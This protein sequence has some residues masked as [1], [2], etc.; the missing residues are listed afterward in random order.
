MAVSVRTR[1]LPKLAISL[2]LALPACHGGGVA[3]SASGPRP[4]TTPSSPSPTALRFTVAPFALPAPLQR[5]VAV[6]AGGTIELAGGL[7]ASDASTSTVDAID[8]EAR[9]VA[10]LG[11]IP[12]PFHDG[13]GAVIGGRVFV[14][15][16]GSASSSD[17]IQRF[18]PAAR[19]GKLVGRLPKALSDLSSVTV[20]SIVYLVGGF[21]DRTP[22]RTIYA[23][24]DGMH[25]Q[26]VGSL[27]RGVR[28]PAVT[29][30]DG[31]VIVAGGQTIVGPT[32]EV[33]VF[34]PATGRTSM[35]ARLPAA[36]AHAAAWSAGGFVFV[37]GGRDAAG[38]PVRTVVRIDPDSDT[39]AVTRPLPHPLADPGVV[40]MGGTTWLLGGWRGRA[41][42]QVLEVSLL[43]AAG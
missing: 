22:Q 43:P 1:R 5:E 29:T 25:I 38:D 13:A 33:V 31:K 40:M 37:A 14:F 8:P 7:N 6:A 16:G 10:N 24:T 11:R 12:V 21:D 9:T 36:V 15:G 42:A 34:D 41:V 35:L 27:P 32:S 23:T 39:A 2:A 4:N 30:L 20:G 3:P 18:D 19:T 17:A 28:Y 26:T